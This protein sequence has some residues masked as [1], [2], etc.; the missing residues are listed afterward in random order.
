MP[1]R[2]RRRQ[3][4]R[5]LRLR[6]WGWLVLWQVTVVADAKALVNGGSEP[7]PSNGSLVHTCLIGP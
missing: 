6:P 5:Y 4:Q 3:R 2:I 7:G 1:E